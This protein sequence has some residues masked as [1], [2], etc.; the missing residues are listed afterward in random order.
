MNTK[1]KARYMFGKT[2]IFRVRIARCFVRESV[3][4]RTI[5][6]TEYRIVGRKTLY[7]TVDRVASDHVPTFKSGQ[8]HTLETRV[9]QT[10]RGH[11]F[12]E[13]LWS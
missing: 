3:R 12:T 11:D 13:Y 8:R 9:H 4:Q 2:G 10:R 1:P 5:Q 6:V 7:V